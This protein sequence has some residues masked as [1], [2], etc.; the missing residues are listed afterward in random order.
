MKVG[1]DLNGKSNIL[2]HLSKNKNTD[3]I[4]KGGLEWKRI[5]II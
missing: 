1:I 2:N 4:M 5:R 3:F